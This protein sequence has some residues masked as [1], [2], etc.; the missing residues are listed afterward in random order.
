MMRV[1]REIVRR[2]MSFE[3]IHMCCDSM[4]VDFRMLVYSFGGKLD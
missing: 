1:T 4:L 2:L 3:M